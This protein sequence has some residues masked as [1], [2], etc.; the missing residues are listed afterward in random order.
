[1][2]NRFW[3]RLSA[4]ILGGAACA[5]V[6]GCGA[7]ELATC[8]EENLVRGVC[9]GVPAGDVCGGERCTA[10]VTCTSVID[11]AS[12]D[13]LT[14][15][16]QAASDG[17]CI[18]VRS[19]RYGVVTVPGGV[20]LL[21][22]SAD[23]VEIEG[24]VLEAG[25][26][27]VVRGLKVGR[28]GVTVQEGATGVRID[29]VRVI[30]ESDY[31]H[32]GIKLGPGSSIAIVAS[33]IAN[34]GHVGIF[35][36]DADVTL[37]RSIVSGAQR[38][39]VEMLGRGC[40]ERCSCTSRPALEVR[41][42]VIRDN[43]VIGVSLHGAT[44][45]LEGV[46]V[47]RTREGVA[48]LAGKFGGGVSAAGCSG[49]LGARQV[50][51]IDSVSFGIL[52]DGSTAMLGD[53]GEDDSI[54]ISRNTLGLWIQNVRQPDGDDCAMHHDERCNVTLHNG[55]LDG[56]FG[57]GIGVT[58]ESRGIILCRSAITA[59][60]FSQLPVF[61]ENDALAVRDVGDGVDWLGDSEVRIDELAFSG[62]ARQSLLLDGPVQGDS[63]IGRI[64]IAAGDEPP[65]QQ[66]YSRGDAQPEGM[67]PPTVSDRRH[68]IPRSLEEL[69]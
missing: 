20:S 23:A 11:V 17:A 22:R 9:A 27:A 32:D 55:K 40:D 48:S 66:S 12:D 2:V 46:D 52:V 65:V 47:I 63:Y 60:A 53:K 19:G 37:E 15:A 18:A 4:A 39:A 62:N 26:G 24:I 13:E 5:A 21:G 25:D 49:I 68:V 44:A 29:S 42:S 7:E 67:A 35:A 56:N 36:T 59:T 10:G 57:V 30:G 28:E 6:A 51:V 69:P 61:D 43:R 38:G 50:R 45:S 34:A 14:S 16:A 64:H 54:E 41:S 33:E 1:M 31:E 3:A 58:G 8:P